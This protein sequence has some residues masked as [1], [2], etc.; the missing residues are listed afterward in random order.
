MDSPRSK[1]EGELVELHQ[2]KDTPEST[3]L[4]QVSKGNFMTA[5]SYSKSGNYNLSNHC[6]LS[7]DL[8]C[9]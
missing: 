2:I 8:S 6:T 5:I 1:A 4:L 3:K 9:Y 7:N